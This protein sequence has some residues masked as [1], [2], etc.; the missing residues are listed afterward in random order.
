MTA[1]PDGRPQPPR[2]RYGLIAVALFGVRVAAGNLVF[3]M[4]PP[5]GR[6]QSR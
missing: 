3:D 6:G 2:R 4:R 5:T 1:S